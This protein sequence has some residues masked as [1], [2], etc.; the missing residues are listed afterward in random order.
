VAEVVKLIVHCGISGS[1]RS[2]CQQSV[3]MG[4]RCTDYIT[5]FLSHFLVFSTTFAVQH[6][7]LPEIKRLATHT[8][9]IVNHG[10]TCEESS[11]TF[12]A[13]ASAAFDD[14]QV[15]ALSWWIS[16]RHSTHESSYWT[17][18]IRD[19]LADNG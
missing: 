4:Q 18:R 1:I 10:P 17:V 12:E 6:P 3:V 13:V 8:D 7:L 2:S 19:R 15:F 9:S 5:H 16:G 14:F 11:G